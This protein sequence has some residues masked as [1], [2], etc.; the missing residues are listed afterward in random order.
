MHIKELYQ[1]L[2]QAEQKSEKLMMEHCLPAT[3]AIP[4]FDQL[5]TALHQSIADKPSDANLYRILH[6]AKLYMMQYKEAYDALATA[7]ELDSKPKDKMM[8][9]QLETIKD[10]KI[11]IKGELPQFRYHPD[12]IRSGAFRFDKTVTCDCCNK[13]TSVYYQGPFYS[14][15]DID[16][17]CPQCIAN[18]EAAKKFEGAFQDYL[19]LEGISPDPSVS[20]ADVYTDQQIDELIYRTPGYHGWQQEQWLGHCGDLCAFVRYVGWDEI[21]DKLDEFV[22]L[23]GD[24]QEFGV[25]LDE[26]P[27]YLHNGGSCQGYLFQCLHC[28]KYRLHG[29]FD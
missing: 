29:D 11:P 26:L 24:C 9:A 13:Q 4:L 19:G 2:H 18:G 1:L 8:L 5:T 16:A 15:D 6:M 21:K 14:K 12:P 10:L 20:N 28:G 25:P 23:E 3:E 17:F 27:K 7:V 22:D